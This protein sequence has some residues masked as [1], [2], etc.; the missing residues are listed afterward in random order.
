MVYESNRRRN[1]FSIEIPTLCLTMCLT[2]IT[3]TGLHVK[4]ARTREQVTDALRT[5]CTKEPTK[6]RRAY[7]YVGIR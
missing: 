3:P 4:H 5:Q 7:V 2:H 6:N 1:A